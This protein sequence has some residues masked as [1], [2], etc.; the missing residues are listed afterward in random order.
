MIDHS[1]VMTFDDSNFRVGCLQL[2]AP[3]FFKTLKSLSESHNKVK[4]QTNLRELYIDGSKNYD[5]RI[6]FHN[7]QKENNG[8]DPNYIF[9]LSLL[10]GNNQLEKI[11]SVEPSPEWR[12]T[13]I[14]IKLLLMTKPPRYD[15]RTVLISYRNNSSIYITY[16]TDSESL[17]YSV[18]NTQ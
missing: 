2:N 18:H 3:T 14:E 6:T 16:M 5:T 4:I 12:T 11:T 8:I 15:F 9:S 17:T 13:T 7:D 1:D 10:K